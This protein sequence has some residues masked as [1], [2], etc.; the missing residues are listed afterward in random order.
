MDLGR[1]SRGRDPA[2]DP[3]AGAYLVLSQSV[4]RVLCGHNCK[5]SSSNTVQSCRG[6]SRGRS[7]G[8]PS[9]GARGRAR[10]GVRGSRS[11]QRD[12]SRS[13]RRSRGRPVETLVW[14]QRD[15]GGVQGIQGQIHCPSLVLSQCVCVCAR[16]CVCV[17]RVLS[18][19]L[20]ITS[21]V[22]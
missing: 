14:I 6:G 7:R 16:V 21:N 9:G 5:V 20:Q 1:R 15:T 4:F 13:R 3:W 19:S 12:P 8:G 10:G 18:G 22:N 2:G 11:S 17:L